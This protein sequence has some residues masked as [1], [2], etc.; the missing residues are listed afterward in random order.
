VQAKQS[1]PDLVLLA[2]GIGLVVGSFSPWVSVLIISIAGTDG[3]FGFVTLTSGIVLI[4]QASSKLWP[5][6]LDVKYSS[7]LG[8]VS[9]VAASASL[10]SLVYV[11]VRIRQVAGEF[12]DVAEP[13][14]VTQTTENIFGDFTEALDEFAQ[15]LTDAFKPRLAMGWYVCMLSILV[16]FTAI[17]INFKKSSTNNPSDTVS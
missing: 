5:N 13:E 9:L 2:A 16:A 1:P 15:T 8:L 4:M 17:F 3:F 12:S 11:A 7:K 14:P 6:F 10:C